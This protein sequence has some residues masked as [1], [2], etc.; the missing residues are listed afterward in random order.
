MSEAEGPETDPSSIA[1]GAV[2]GTIWLASTNYIGFASNILI[3]LVVMRILDLA[4]VGAY[5]LAFAVNEFVALVGAFSVELAVIHFKD[6]DDGTLFDTG[7]I[8]T[9]VLGLSAALIGV[10]L[11]FALAPFE[12]FT[13]EVR[14]FIV[15]LCLA[16]PIQFLSGIAL[17]RMETDFRYRGVSLAS[18]ATSILPNLLALVLALLGGGAISLVSRDVGIAV[19]SYLVYGFASR[20]RCG[21]RWSSR[22]AARILRYSNLMFLT[23]VMEVV[24]QRFDRVLIGSAIGKEALAS[25]HGGRYLSEMG[26]TFTQPVSRLSFNVYSRM[27]N[28][29]ERLERA[30]RL[31]NFFL[32]RGA[33]LIALVLGFLARDL[34]MVTY[35]PK[36]LP[37]VPT[38]RLL[39][40]YAAALPILTNMILLLYGRGMM[41]ESVIVR[42]AQVVIFIPCA[43][44]ATLLV[45]PDATGWALLVTT[46]AGMALVVWFQRGIVAFA[47]RELFLV[48]ALALAVGMASALFLAPL[49]EGH[50]FIPSAVRLSMVSTIYL[51]ALVAIDRRAIGEHYRYLRAMSV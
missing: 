39:A 8:L 17:A 23:R 43:I 48:P 11:Y 25:Y 6:D 20:W 40:P 34:V 24:L 18:L 9:L 5:A 49:V 2:R 46:V 16:R 15:V 37:S 31:V 30:Y 28:D 36:W 50:G 7:Y 4:D 14:L 3:T 12:P 26:Y 44:V 21:W 51:A 1:R 29:P 45:G 35:G 47:G 27:K 10:V 22:S 33:I 19:L 13:K 32:V 41:R 42:A 38:A